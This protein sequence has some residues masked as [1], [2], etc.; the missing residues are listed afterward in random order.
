MSVRADLAAEIGAAPGLDVV[1][2]TA[3]G[4]ETLTRAA[5]TRPDL[6]LLGAGAGGPRLVTVTR[7]LLAAAGPPKVI[8][9]AVPEHR[10]HWREALQAGAS[11]LLPRGGPVRDLLYAI[12]AVVAG[13][14]LIAPAFA[15]Q[16]TGSGA[17]TDIPSAL[18]A[19]PVRVWPRPGREPV[20]G[21]VKADD[22]LL[23]R[24]VHDVLGR[25][26]AAINRKGELV[27]RL[28]ATEPDRARTEL[29]TVL[30]LARRSMTEVR[31]LVGGYRLGDLATEIEGVRADLEAL[32]T[33]VEVTRPQ[34]ALPQPIQEVFGWVVREASANVIRHSEASHCSI[35][36]WISD[37]TAGLRILN[38]G[39]RQRVSPSGSGLGG[40]MTRLRAVGG[41]LTHGPGP[42]SSY[43]VE[44]TAPMNRSDWWRE[45]GDQAGPGRGR[46]PDQGSPH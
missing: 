13:Y 25:T 1:G 3:G 40:L 30:A 11:G 38:D 39:A 2:E 29:E 8:I 16:A 31:A 28:L 45:D 26:L 19:G 17:R 23:A 46:S 41:T 15:A 18:P 20:H 24:D 42:R 10:E 36:V 33:R 37:R 27:A 9:L 22:R 4:E 32:G 14:V 35:E 34:A 43:R 7:R 21:V 5:Q 44:A 12:P 6:V